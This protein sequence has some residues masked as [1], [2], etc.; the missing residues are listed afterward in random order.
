MNRFGG[1]ALL[2]EAHHRR[3]LQSLVP[4]SV[5]SFSFL[6]VVKD[7]RTRPSWTPIHWNFEAEVET[8]LR[9]QRSHFSRPLTLTL[10]G[11]GSGIQSY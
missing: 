9:L 6:P 7:V 1:V 8:L 4:S 3:V 10:V 2:E 5:P 11:Q